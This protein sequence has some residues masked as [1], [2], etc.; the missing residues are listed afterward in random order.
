MAGITMSSLAR[1]GKKRKEGQDFA[2]YVFE[3]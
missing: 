3:T 1:S 2:G